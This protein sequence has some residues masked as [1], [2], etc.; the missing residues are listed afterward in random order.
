IVPV[1]YSQGAQLVHNSVRLLSAAVLERITALVT[2]GDPD[3][4]Q[5][6]EGIPANDILIICHSD[7][8]IYDGSLFL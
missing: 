5:G 3:R 6:I 1:G 8:I 7:D 4:S 2:F